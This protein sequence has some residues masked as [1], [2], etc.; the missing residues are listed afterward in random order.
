[1]PG[2][3]TTASNHQTIKPFKEN[4][5]T[6]FCSS[7]HRCQWQFKGVFS[8]HVPYVPF[9]FPDFGIQLGATRVTWL[10]F[11]FF[12]GWGSSPRFKRGLAQ[13]IPQ[14]DGGFFHSPIVRW[15][16]SISLGVGW[17]VGQNSQE[18]EKSSLFLG[19]TQRIVVIQ[20]LEIRQSGFEKRNKRIQYT[21][22]TVFWRI[23]MKKWWVGKWCSFRTWCDFGYLG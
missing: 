2:F 19:K 7:C 23:D 21:L 3:C 6:D 20:H 10:P 17:K 12:M 1:M 18:L 22:M 4:L 13:E 9:P 11:N 16:Y 15:P 8:F 5:K 14:D